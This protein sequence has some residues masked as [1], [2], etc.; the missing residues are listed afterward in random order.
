MRWSI[1]TKFEKSISK[2][3]L[4]AIPFFSSWLGTPDSHLKFEI[5][6]SS[7]RKFW[8][9][10]TNRKSLVTPPASQVRNF[11]KKFSNENQPDL[12]STIDD[13]QTQTASMTSAS[14][15]DLRLRQQRPLR[16]TTRTTA[17]MDNP[18]LP[19]L[20]LLS[21]HPCSNSRIGGIVLIKGERSSL[22]L[23]LLRTHN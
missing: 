10:I 17:T 6:K 11:N 16:T 15:R 9:R 12:R 13:L 22:F 19:S 14:T 18:P 2:L 3:N 8:S 23:L 7:D 4:L 21:N 5:E 20:R 1:D